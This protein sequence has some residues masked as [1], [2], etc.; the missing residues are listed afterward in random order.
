[1]QPQVSFSQMN[2]FFAVVAAEEAPYTTARPL[3]GSRPMRAGLDA[4]G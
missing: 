1:M 2:L 3:P 4:V